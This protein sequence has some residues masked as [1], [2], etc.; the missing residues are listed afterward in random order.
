M[1][2]N[3]I[4]HSAAQVINRI[5]FFLSAIVN[6]G[7]KRI[8]SI[9]R[10]DRI[11]YSRRSVETQSQVSS[12]HQALVQKLLQPQEHSTVLLK[13]SAISYV[14]LSNMSLRNPKVV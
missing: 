6:L 13:R 3:F 1:Y 7:L 2:P 9:L 10:T 14:K 11:D 12:S 8:E 5:L 4:E